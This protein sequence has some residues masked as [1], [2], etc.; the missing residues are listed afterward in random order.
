MGKYLQIMQTFTLQNIPNL[1]TCVLAAL[2]LFS[3]TKLPSLPISKWKRPLV[4]GSGNAAA[5]GQI[6]FN[7]HDA[8]YANEN[9]YQEKLL[10][11]KN[12]DAVLIFSASGGK[13]APLMAKEAKKRKKP[14]YLIT[15]NQKALA[16][17]ELP[18]QNVFIFPKNRE[19]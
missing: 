15:N 16:A 8:V 10:K 6:I 12:I 14:V 18:S 17:K 4:I 7:D 19:P 5:I 2:E 13:H 11:I 1:D 9:S 3:K